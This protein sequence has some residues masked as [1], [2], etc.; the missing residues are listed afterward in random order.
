MEAWSS[1]TVD[2]FD[3]VC[4]RVL[5]GDALLLQVEGDPFEKG[6]LSPRFRGDNSFMGYDPVNDV[7]LIIWTSLTISLDG[8][9]TANTIMQK[10][11]DQ[12][13]TVSPLQ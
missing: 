10:M 6:S 2:F 13:Y 11:L 8:K 12:I 1:G 3:G 9:T 5:P 4:V 7:T